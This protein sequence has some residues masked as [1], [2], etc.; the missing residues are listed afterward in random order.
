[1]ARKIDALEIEV[2]MRAKDWMTLWGVLQEWRKTPKML[3]SMLHFWL[4]LCIITLIMQV[5]F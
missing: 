1:M 3:W 4:V 2:P 5:V